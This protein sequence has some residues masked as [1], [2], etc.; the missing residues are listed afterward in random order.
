MAKWTKREL[1]EEGFAQSA[2]RAKMI[3]PFAMPLCCSNEQWELLLKG[4]QSL[5]GESIGWRRDL[6]K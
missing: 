4:T 2:L 6:L 1:I 3:V 5:Y